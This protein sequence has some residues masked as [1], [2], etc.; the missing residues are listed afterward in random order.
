[1]TENP[2]PRVSRVRKPGNC[3][4]SIY[5]HR[6]THTSNSIFGVTWSSTAASIT[7][8]HHRSQNLSNICVGSF[9]CLYS[10]PVSR[11]GAGAV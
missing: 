9:G 7:G 1:M 6:H 2:G 3:V 8:V 11:D 4:L 10:G 5:V